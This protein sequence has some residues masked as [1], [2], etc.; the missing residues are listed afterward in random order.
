ML[1]SQI[2]EDAGTNIIELLPRANPCSLEDICCALVR[3]DQLVTSLRPVLRRCI[4]HFIEAVSTSSIAGDLRRVADRAVARQR[5]GRSGPDYNGH[6]L[7]K[8]RPHFRHRLVRVQRP[9]LWA[10]RD[11]FHG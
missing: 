5:P 3:K 10:P 7:W 8:H 4:S 6:I 9:S 1:A 11:L 2:M